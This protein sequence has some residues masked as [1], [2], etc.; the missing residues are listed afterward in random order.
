MRFR[1]RF[2]R[3]AA[4]SPPMARNLQISINANFFFHILLLLE[5]LYTTFCNSK[6]KRPPIFGWLSAALLVSENL[7]IE[8]FRAVYFQIVGPLLSYFDGQ[9]PVVGEQ[10]I[11]CGSSLE[12]K[13]IVPSKLQQVVTFLAIDSAVTL[14]DLLLLVYNRWQIK[15]AQRA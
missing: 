14:G 5:R 4:C 1:S 9:P 2:E 11:Y 3:V 10:R 13:Q 12:P 8:A 7:E 15:R 6:R